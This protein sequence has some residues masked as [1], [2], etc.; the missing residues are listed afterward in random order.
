MFTMETQG[1]DSLVK[2]AQQ[3][4]SSI[5]EGK[6]QF[7]NTH[8]LQQINISS[9]LV[10]HLNRMIYSQPDPKWYKRTNSLKNSIKI[11]VKGES[12]SVYLDGDYL[13]SASSN[14]P[15]MATGFDKNVKGVNYAHLVESGYIFQNV[16][17]PLE[18]F[19]RNYIME[20]RPFMAETWSEVQAEINPSVIVSPLLRMWSR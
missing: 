8:I 19:G 4:R 5:E 13:R 3:M 14:E 16:D 12:V 2:K 18:D 9:K 10:R 15:S 11:D 17:N 6:Q 7:I 1:F 20:A